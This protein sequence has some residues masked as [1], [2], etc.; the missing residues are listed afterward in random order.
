M[1]TA[2]VKWSS[3]HEHGALWW[4]HLKLRK[5]LFVDEKGWSIPHNVDA[6]WDQYDT[7]NTV[8]VITYED[9]T[10]LAASRLNPCDFESCGWSYMIKDAVNGRLPGI[11]SD[12]L[13]TPPTTTSVWEATRFTVNPLLSSEARNQALTANAIA[14][15][16]HG[17]SM[18][19]AALIALMP[20]AYL[21]WLTKIGL[22]T[23]RLGPTK[24]DS[25]GQRICVMRLELQL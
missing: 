17:R 3:I 8:Y 19:L 14:L 6:E 11:P 23:K 9:E 12:I 18:G 13:E 24:L 2:I 15:A 10:P 4:E 22:P 1:Q 5:Q 25:E 7:A 20:P 21:R 16:E